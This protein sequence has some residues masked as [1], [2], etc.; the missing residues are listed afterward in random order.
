MSPSSNSKLSLS[1]RELLLGALA[2]AV[3]LATPQSRLLAASQAHPVKLKLANGKALEIHKEE[4]FL[5]DGVRRRRVRQGVFGLA[6]G[7]RIEVRNGKLLTA[8]VG[9]GDAFVENDWTDWIEF[10]GDG[11]SQPKPG[12]SNWLKNN[13]QRRSG[14]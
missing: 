8:A 3:T 5:L 1:K 6:S 9:P 7:G 12:A 4:V 2:T 10:G 11:G 13:G 14:Q